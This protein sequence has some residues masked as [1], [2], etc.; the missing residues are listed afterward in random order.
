MP[1]T[2][3]VGGT[4]SIV[5]FAVVEVPPPDPEPVFVPL[6]VEPLL[7]EPLPVDVPWVGAELPVGAEP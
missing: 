3:S 7:V 5:T 1:S 2:F 6:P 4:Q